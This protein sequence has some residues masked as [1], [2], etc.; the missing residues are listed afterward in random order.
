[1]PAEM[2][3]LHVPVVNVYLTAT[4]LTAARRQMQTPLRRKCSILSV[5]SMWREDVQTA[6]SAAESVLRES[7]FT[8][9]TESLSRTLIG[10]TESFR[11]ER[12]QSQKGRLQAILSTMQSRAV[13]EKGDNICIR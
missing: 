1:M 8:C 4:N 13:C 10:F 6:A 3:V 5:P 11:P 9:L 7:P 12:T 2:Y